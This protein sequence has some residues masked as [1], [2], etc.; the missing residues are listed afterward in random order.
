ME[1][2][3]RGDVARAGAQPV[4]RVRGWA[5]RFRAVFRPREA[6]ARMEEEFRFHVDMETARLVRDGLAPDAAR[7]QALLT[8]GGLDAHRETMRDE[9]GARW[10]D[11]LGADL[12]YAL[13]AMRRRPGAAVAV[14]LTLGVGIGVNGIVVGYVNALLLR[15]VPARACISGTRERARSTRWPT[16]TTWTIATGAACSRTWRPCQACRSMW[17]SPAGRA[18]PTCSGARW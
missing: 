5:A 13:R 6:E 2:L 1:A 9:R 14:A 10:L 15:P 11:D 8:F 17:W 18:R 3:R 12:R 16:T 7:R 4:S